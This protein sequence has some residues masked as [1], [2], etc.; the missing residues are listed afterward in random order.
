MVAVNRRYDIDWI[1][2]IAIGLLLVYHVAIGFQPWGLMVGFI[3]NAESW[4]S[5]WFPM[6]ALNVWRIPLLFFVSGMGVYFA[7]QNRDWKTLLRERA[8]RIFVP[9]L[10]GAVAIVPIHVYL[11][12][13]YFA[14]P[15]QYRPDPAHLWF[16][17]NI[18][19]YFLLFLPVFYTLKHYE[20]SAFAQG[21]KRMFRTPLGLLPVLALF[22]A[23]A[24]LINPRPFELYANTWHGF[25]LGL[26]AFVAGFLFVY[27]GPI[28]WSMLLQWRWL[29][30]L[31]AVGLYAVR[32]V[33][34]NL[35]APGYLLAIESNSWILAIFAFGHKHFNRP[36]KALRYLS[37]AAYPVYILHMVFI[38]LGALLFFPLAIDV[39][40]KFVLLLLFT[41][42]GS[43]GVYEFIVRRFTIARVLFGLNA[44]SSS[45][46]KN[47][48][49]LPSPNDA[50]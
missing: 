41:A 13:R 18:F 14:M 44:G 49:T 36:G 26:I 50:R 19:V 42:V 9:Y 11:I 12:N 37:A 2:V 22:V 7:M 17:G 10:F 15:F 38:Y 4:S 8:G 30:L 32:L 45:E 29:F 27:S 48:S 46:Q 34:L 39:P 40:V 24:G 28:F 23:E 3:T 25:F 1:R 16:L 21:L 33:Y 5:L 6:T 31:A 43:L 35:N 20:H 47:L